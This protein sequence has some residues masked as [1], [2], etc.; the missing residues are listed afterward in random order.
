MPSP[1]T[2]EVP[3]RTKNSRMFLKSGFFSR[4]SLTHRARSS[5]GVG[6]LSLKLE[7][8]SSTRC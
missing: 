3:I 6:N 4:L 2:M 5:S 1:M 8:S 7:I